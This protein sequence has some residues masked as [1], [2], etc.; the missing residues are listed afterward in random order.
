[1]LFWRPGAPLVSLPAK[2]IP[3]GLWRENQGGAHYSK[4]EEGGVSRM[5]VQGREET[6]VLDIGGNGWPDW[7][8]S[9]EGI[10]FLKFSKLSHPT[11]QFLDDINTLLECQGERDGS[12]VVAGLPPATLFRCPASPWREPDNLVEI[13]A[14][15][16]YV[17]SPDAKSCDRVLP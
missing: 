17:K 12:R 1:M 7:A 4:F 11:I 8:L 3:Y 6:Q 15:V 16:V 10:Y 13:S 5:P 14:Q 2:L 9:A